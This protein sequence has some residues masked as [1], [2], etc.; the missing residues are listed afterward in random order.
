[1]KVKALIYVKISL[2]DSFEII[3]LS[4]KLYLKSKNL[5]LILQNIIQN[6]ILIFGMFVSNIH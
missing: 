2:S 5:I 4:V 6:D 1:M 3:R